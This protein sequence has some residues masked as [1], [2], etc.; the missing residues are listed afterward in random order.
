MDLNLYFEPVELDRPEK[1]PRTEKAMF[2]QNMRINTPSTPIDEI[3]NYNV[4][5][6]G[7]SEDRN[8]FNRGA[9]LAPDRIRSSLY[10]LYR[11]NEKV[12]I[13]D[14]GN[15]KKTQTVGDTYYGVRDVVLELLR[16]QVL[17]VIIGGTQD[18]TYGAYMAYEKDHP[19]VKVISVDSRIDVEEGMNNG[20]IEK[21]LS[22]NKLFE[23]TN[24]GHQQY[25]VNRDTTEKLGKFPFESVRLGQAR[26]NLEMAEPVL[27]DAHL[28]S[29][30]V[31][32][33]RQSDSPGTAFPSPNGFM[34]EEACQIARY[35]GLSDQ[36]SCLGIFEVNPEFDLH[37]QTTNLASQMI[38]YFI[39]GYTQRRAEKP[40]QGNP[41]FRIFVV[42]HED[43][44]HE[45]RF[46]KSQVTGRWWLDV[47]H[48]ESGGSVAVPCSSAEYEQAG[49]HEIPDLWWKV[50][51]RIN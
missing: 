36:V 4:A 41:D 31:S 40:A 46:Y 35:A 11:I 24:I 6:F 25:L 13:I 30:D 5:I 26:E 14:L 8:S 47:P 23:Y 43:M 3:S 19:A 51:Q 45:L 15:L 20:W 39:E 18:I 17:V 1:S 22:G 48:L 7:V 16:N 9:A 34:A 2:G 10:N 29:F 38:W 21:V 28:V 50:F 12:R 27:R 32:S 42:S 33:I 49:R 37:D 44:E